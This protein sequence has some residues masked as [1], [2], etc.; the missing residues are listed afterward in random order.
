MNGGAG[1][2]AE[3]PPIDLSDAVE[4]RRRGV[5]SALAD[6]SA[7]IGAVRWCLVGG[8]MVLI[9]ARL[10]G[11]W[12]PRPTIDGDVLVDLVADSGALRRVATTLVELGFVPEMSAGEPPLPIWCTRF[13]RDR[14]V[15]DLLAPDGLDDGV[16]LT[17]IAPGITLQAPGGRRALDDVGP[18]RL[19]AGEVS[20]AVQLP[21]LLGALLAKAAATLELDWEDKHLQDFAFLLTLVERP[22]DLVPKLRAVDVEALTRVGEVLAD[23][24][25]I[26][27]QGIDRDHAARG[28]DTM[29]ALLG[30]R[31]AGS[32]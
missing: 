19:R 28:R 4:L 14:A 21:S 24:A 26:A 3:P 18:V 17:T 29:A 23:H 9:H 31:R 12:P 22:A 25:R 13:R 15:L 20:V 7:H 16:D 27:W 8:L 2:T 30:I 5:I 10:R 32:T 6:L 11:R 1:A